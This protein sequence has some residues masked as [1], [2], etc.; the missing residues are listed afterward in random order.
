MINDTPA[1]IKTTD[2][3]ALRYL[4]C[5]LD[6]KPLLSV[7]GL[8]EDMCFYKAETF[9]HVLLLATYI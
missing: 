1:Q 3:Q 5:A 9:F 7:V 4:P 2:A 8:E 6:V